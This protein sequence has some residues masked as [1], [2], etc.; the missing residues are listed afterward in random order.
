MR[1]TYSAS[2]S[3]NAPHI[4][5]PGLQIVFG[6]APTD[7]FPRDTGMFGEADQFTGQEFERPARPPGGWLG[8]GGRDQQRLLLAGQ[9]SLCCRPRGSSLSAA[10][11]LPSTKRPVVRVHGRAAHPNIAGNVLIAGAGIR[12][13][14]SLRPLELARRML[15]AA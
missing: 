6:Q 12:R 7:G 8:T 14:R 4:L 9:L 13:H 2:T 11:K 10:S 3:R 1:A 15:A 5:T